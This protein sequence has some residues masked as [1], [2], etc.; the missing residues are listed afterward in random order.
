[1]NACT[2]LKHKISFTG[3]LKN[4]NQINLSLRYEGHLS[5]IIAKFKGRRAEGLKCQISEIFTFS[6]WMRRYWFYVKND[7]RK[8]HQIFTF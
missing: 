3:K 6:L 1:M 7:F 4:I 8:F 2:I 5:V